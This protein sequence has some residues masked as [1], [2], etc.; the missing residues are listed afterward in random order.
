MTASTTQPS[1]RLDSSATESMTNVARSWS[2]SAGSGSGSPMRMPLVRASAAASARACNASRLRDAAR[3]T[4]YARR[5]AALTANTMRAATFSGS[6]TVNVWIGG[7]K[8]Q[9][10]S[11]KAA[12]AAVTATTPPPTAAMTTV[13]T[14]YSIRSVAS[15]TWS[16]TATSTSVSSGSPT[17]VRTQPA[18]W[19]AGLGP[20]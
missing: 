19:R 3:S 17:S 4:K 14:R 11:R 16:R 7:V 12:T 18:R 2:S 13:T 9:F 10:D 15:D 8:Y 5:R 1:S 6:P 20:R